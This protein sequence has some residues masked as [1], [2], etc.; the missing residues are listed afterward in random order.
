MSLPRVAVIGAGIAGLTCAREL[1][2]AGLRP[3]VFD[4]GRGL[5]GRLA[6]RRAGDGL[7][8]DHGATGLVPRDP[9][10]AAVLDGAVQAGAG[11]R[12]TP[13][14]AA[15]A[16]FVGLPGMS[17]LARHLGAGLD[18]RGQV[19]V[20]AVRTGA[21]ECAVVTPAGEERFDRVV[22]ALPAPQAA[23]LLQGDVPA[24]LGD[25]RMAPCLTLM[26]AFAAGDADGRDVQAGDGFHRIVIDSRKPGR[27]GGGV[28]C[29]VAQADA[30]VSRAH[31]E[32][33]METVAQ[34]LL[35]M[36]CARIGRRPEEAV[37]AVAH[38]WR[39]ALTEVAAG[40]AC[41][42][43]GG[44]RLFLGGDWCLGPTAED[45]WASGSAL[46]AAVLAAG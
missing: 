45:G 36:L 31:L 35:P 44:G 46:A 28:D 3:V 39:F 37:H 22:M 11:A 29:L 43:G 9:R 24:A 18:V 23:R 1:A 6:T 13:S 4:K 10:F 32:E 19:T 21:G 20:A 38:R 41:L 34:R 12:W 42:T 27:G 15:G 2:A 40:V 8:F 33:E 17:G 26:A 25:V 14:G 16:E 30:G 7:A 5:G